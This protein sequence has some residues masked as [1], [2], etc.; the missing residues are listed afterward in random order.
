MFGTDGVRGVA[1][2]KLNCD[3]AYKLGQAAAVVLTSAVHKAKILI[4]RDTR[5]SGDMLESALIAG[6]CSAGAEADTLGVIP[7]SA[8]AHLTRHYGAD[9]GAVIS[10]SHNSFEYNGIK[11]FNGQGYKLADM[12]EDEIERLVLSGRRPAICPPGSWW[13]ARSS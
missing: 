10:A 8:V 3:L 9:A 4:G 7:T 5:I 2:D 6:I 11:F 1:N 13:G 12:I